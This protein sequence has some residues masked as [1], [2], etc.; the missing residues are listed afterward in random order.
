MLLYLMDHYSG[1]QYFMYNY[2]SWRTA[3][4]AIISCDAFQMTIISCGEFEVNLSIL[5][6]SGY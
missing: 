6:R 3:E 1:D 4:R 2:I 5:M